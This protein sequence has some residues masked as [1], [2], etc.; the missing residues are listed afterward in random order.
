MRRV[1]V[2]GLVTRYGPQSVLP[3]QVVVAFNRTVFKNVIFGE[4]RFWTFLNVTIHIMVKYIPNT[5]KIISL[6]WFQVYWNITQAKQVINLLL[7]GSFY[8]VIYRWIQKGDE[9]LYTVWSLVMV[10]NQL[11]AQAIEAFNRTVLKNV[12]FREK[13]FRTFLNITVRI[14]VKYIP[15]TE[16]IISNILKYNPGKAN[17]KFIIS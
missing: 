13:R 10:R 9:L 8:P 4:K 7:L 14:K 15:H 1:I 17:N 16:K 2:Y 3:A 5:E 12:I 6:Y 11:S